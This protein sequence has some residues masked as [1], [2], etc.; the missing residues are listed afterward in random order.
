MKDTPA[1]GWAE[2]PNVVS[3]FIVFPPKAT[4]GAQKEWTDVG[5]SEDGW[6]LY[7]D[8]QPVTREHAPPLTEDSVL[9]VGYDPAGEGRSPGRSKDS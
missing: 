3:G 5:Y 4:S 7:V 1:E 6:T 8:G 9:T 2:A